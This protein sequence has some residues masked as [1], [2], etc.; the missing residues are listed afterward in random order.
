[1][2]HEIDVLTISLPHQFFDLTNLIPKEINTYRTFPGPFYYLTYKF[3]REPLPADKDRASSISRAFWQR[4]AA[5]H[6]KLHAVIESL[7]LPDIY[8][9]WLP[10]A[11]KKGRGLT[12]GK[13]YDF[14]I[15]SSEPRSS[16]LA[17]YFLKKHSGVPWIADYGDPWIYPLPLKREFVF[18]TKAVEMLERKVIKQVD[19]ITFTSEGTARLYQERYPFLDPKKMYIVTQ[20]FDPHIFSGII[21]ESGAG[22]RIVYC[23]SFYHKLRDPIEFFKAIKEMEVE[24]LEVV[25]AGRINE[26]SEMI[27]E[28]GLSSKIKDRGFV[29]HEQ[30]L[31]LEKGASVLLHIGNAIDLQ[32]PGKI[33]EYMGSGRP[34]LCIRGSK[35]DESADMVLRYNKGIVVENNK[36][37]IKEGIMRL[38]TLWRED[39]LDSSYN[40]GI[41]EDASWTRGAEKIDGIMRAL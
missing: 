9:E 17:G 21:G 32:V 12:A 23:G 3:S 33:Y 8:A 40:T 4:A 41:P 28:Y 19:A 22:F 36:E 31:S 24:D 39:R 29:N 30:A 38:Y 16:H 18:K 10:F 2:G 15:S 6:K 26:Y 34:I 27:N 20:G 14:I 11:L 5:F 13:K 35:N 7:A 25:I 1:M 37:E